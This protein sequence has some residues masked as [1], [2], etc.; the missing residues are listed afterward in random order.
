MSIFY[1]IFEI[2]LSFFFILEFCSYLPAGVWIFFFKTYLR[3]IEENYFF[4]MQGV[5]FRCSRENECHFRVGSSA[6]TVTLKTKSLCFSKLMV[7]RNSLSNFTKIRMI[8]SLSK[9]QFFL[10]FGQISYF[11]QH[12]INIIESIWIIF[13]QEKLKFQ[14]H[15]D[16]RAD[17]CQMK[18]ISTD[19]EARFFEI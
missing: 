6:K 3:C 16:A 17:P 8:S 2:S 1:L 11:F 7:H 14:K 18:F 10:Q 4:H 12:S 19:Y 13:Y 5:G 15:P 9:I